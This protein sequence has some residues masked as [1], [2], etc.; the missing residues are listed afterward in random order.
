MNKVEAK[1]A[2]LRRLNALLERINQAILG[3]DY[4][5]RSELKE[6]RDKTIERIKMVQANKKDQLAL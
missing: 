6:L 5:Q 2:E 4:V 3:A 1:K